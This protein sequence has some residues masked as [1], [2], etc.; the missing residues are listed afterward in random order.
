LL[1][2]ILP[3][4]RA[5][6]YRRKKTLSDECLSR[7]NSWSL[8]SCA[9]PAGSCPADCTRV[10]AYDPANSNR[11]AAYSQQI[12]IGT[13]T[14]SPAGTAIL[15]PFSSILCISLPV[16]MPVN[17]NAGLYSFSNQSRRLCSL[18]ISTRWEAIGFVLIVW[19][20]GVS[21]SQTW[22]YL[23]VGTVFPS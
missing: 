2:S 15:A 20:S 22:N 13:I 21:L 12:P 1:L 16:F 9:F 8:S 14:S 5:T 3:G 18:C 19:S 11:H 7:A 6:T 17:S 10:Q 4:E 23:H